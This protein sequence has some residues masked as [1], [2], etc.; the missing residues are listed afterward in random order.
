MQGEEEKCGDEAHVQAADGEQVCRPR[1]PEGVFEFKVEPLAQAD[2]H[3][4]DETGGAFGVDGVYVGAHALAELKQKPPP[5]P[6]L[7]WF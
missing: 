1:S 7:P 4:F 5:A 6:F 2:G 3:R